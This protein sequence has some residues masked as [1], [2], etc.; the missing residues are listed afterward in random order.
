MTPMKRATVLAAALC[1]ATAARADDLG[2]F[3]DKVI[4]AHG[5]AAAW[6]KVARIEATGTVTPAMRAGDGKM[7]RTWSGY[8]DLRVEIVYADR[9]EVRAL[10]GGKG[11][12]NGRESNAMELAAMKMQAARVALPRLL[13]EKKAS[14]RDLGTKDGIRSIE[15]SLDAPMTVTVDIDAATARIVRSTS[16]SGEMAFG[17]AYGDYRKVHDLLLAFHEENSAMGMKTA[18]IQ[19]DKA[20]VK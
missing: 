20:D 12:N 16:R 11:K 2:A 15:I 3:V 18:D 4:A 6:S 5:G 14:L 7:T 9:T 10:E 19:F 1:L 13:E 8:D 17:T